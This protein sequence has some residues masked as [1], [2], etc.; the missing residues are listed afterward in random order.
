MGMKDG[1]GFS[2]CGA[3]PG[4]QSGGAGFQTRGNSQFLRSRAL[5]LVAASQPRIFPQPVE[6]PMIDLCVERF[7][8]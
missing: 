4:L 1:V 6:R 7:S 3:S 5:A 2:P 8:A